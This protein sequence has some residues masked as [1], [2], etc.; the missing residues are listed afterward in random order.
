MPINEY[1]FADSSAAVKK[2]GN[3]VPSISK[4][5]TKCTKVDAVFIS[6]DLLAL[7]ENV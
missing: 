2:K 4:I 3:S 6:T 5:R 7:T 1:F